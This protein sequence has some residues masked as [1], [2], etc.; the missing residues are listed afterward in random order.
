MATEKE[1]ELYCDRCEERIEYCASCGKE[2]TAGNTI[3]CFDSGSKHY[4]EDCV[5]EAQAESSG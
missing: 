2:F 1:N 5:K 4:C 3:Y